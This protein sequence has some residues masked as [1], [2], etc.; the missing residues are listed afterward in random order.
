MWVLL[1]IQLTTSTASGNEFQHYH[2]G[3]YTKKEVCEIAKNEA[4][5]LVTNDNPLKNS[6]YS[7]RVV[8]LKE[9]RGK[10]I[11]YDK[12]GKVV[13]I[14]R[15]KK[16]SNCVCE[17]EEMTEF[18]KADLNNNGVIEKAEWNKIAFRRP[19]FGND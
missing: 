3:S 7:N 9:F 18:S 6:L 12:L 14:T 1:W 5:V 19:S 2:V 4:K 8:I 16:N 11:I 17:G 15:E 13:I 10:Y